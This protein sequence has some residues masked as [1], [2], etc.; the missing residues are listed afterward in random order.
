VDDDR[1][2]IRQWAYAAPNAKIN[3]AG[4]DII[5][6]TIAP[7][8]RPGL[9]SV[10]A[11]TGRLPEH[12]RGRDEISAELLE[13]VVDSPGHAVVLHGTGGSGKS[14]LALWLA[15]KAAAQQRLVWWVSA[16]DAQTLS[17]GL[18][19]VAIQAKANPE[20]VAM[21]WAG[22]G[23]APDELWRALNAFTGRW[24]L[25]L[26]NAD[27]PDVLA[28]A[29]RLSEGNGW[30]RTPRSDHGLVVV[31]S[32]QGSPRTWPPGTILRPVTSLEP[33]DAGQVLMDLAGSRAGSPTEA[34]RLGRR[35]GGLP[36]ALRLA[37]S[38]LASSDE[39]L[40][41]PGAETP[42]TFADYLA[43]LDERVGVLDALPGDHDD[44]RRERELISRTWELSLDLLERRGHPL[45]R[46]LLRLL[47]CFGQAP[48]PV[49]MLDAELMAAA[50]MWAKITPESIAR[51]LPAL[52]DLGLV[53]R[54]ELDGR[55]ALSLHPLVR[56]TSRQQAGSELD[57]DQHI[58]TVVELLSATT[59][60]YAM[61][62]QT[63]PRWQA[64]AAHAESA[65]ELCRAQLDQVPQPVVE[66]AIAMV[67]R[68]ATFRR[69]V[70]E[71]EQE[72][73]DVRAIL[74]T[75]QRT[76]GELHPETLATRADLALLR[77]SPAQAEDELREVLDVQ[78]RVLGERHVDTLRT[79]HALAGRR[80]DRGEWSAAEQTYRHA[81]KILREDHGTDY[82]GTLAVWHGLALSL[83]KQG[84]LAEATTE[85]RAA[86]A[87]HRRVLGP[88]HD[89][90]LMTLDGYATV[91]AQQPES[92][93]AAEQE[94]RSL[95][96]VCSRKGGDTSEATLAARHGLAI[97]L[98]RQ[99]R[100]AAARAEYQAV[101]DLA[102][103]L[104]G[105]EDPRILACRANLAGLDALMGDTAS[106][107]TELRDVLAIERRLYGDAHPSTLRTR[108]DLVPLIAQADRAAAASEANDI[109]DIASRTLGREHPMVQEAQLLRRALT[110]VPMSR[111][112]RRRQER[113][114]A[115][116]NRR[117]R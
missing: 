33:A 38:Y 47:S 94:F 57:V 100:H 101:L 16:D 23:S 117:R 31:T 102:R 112:D 41:V 35:L 1:P 6:I 99:G 32:R 67:R 4:G 85:F 106:A 88:E 105:D 37:G 12:L 95:V 40:L 96:E 53:D 34:E 24:V 108:L 86:L 2:T 98:R 77:T 30:L 28:G 70:H 50:P 113:A 26:D 63:W 14:S 76:L 61:T 54:A 115:R 62:P 43:A 72:A 29:G 60:G 79:L 51:L 17:E 21:A 103:P 91:L 69:Y 84:R 114:A 58:S 97:T 3:Q 111:R 20:K 74:E 93:D 44:Q 18:R 48:V 25:I 46:K 22:Y 78:R 27:D 109:I 42:Q 90:T 83:S 104:W 75:Q 52:L 45:A 49:D 81:L 65:L 68:A 15:S 39:R 71:A 56:D 107:G 8:D 7:K 19:E 87:A 55:Q 9:V 116:N 89:S 10:V 59:D 64:L 82:V 80:R 110:Q 11:P 92:V 36:L 73:L 66:R 5:D 13:K